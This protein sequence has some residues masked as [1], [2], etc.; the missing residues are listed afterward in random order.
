MKINYSLVEDELKALTKESYIHSWKEL[1]AGHYRINDKL[2]IWPKHHNWHSLSTNK[3][4][5]Y[6]DISEFLKGFFNPKLR[7]F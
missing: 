7:K 4:G 2:D 5:K 3:R 1:G 6:W